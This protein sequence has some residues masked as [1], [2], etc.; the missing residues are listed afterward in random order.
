M[1]RQWII[2][3]SLPQLH[4]NW[5]Q[6]LPGSNLCMFS[7]GLSCPGFARLSYKENQG[8]KVLA[9]RWYYVHMY[10]DIGM[11][12]TIVMLNISVLSMILELK[13]SANFYVCGC[14]FHQGQLGVFIYCLWITFTALICM[15]SN[16]LW[17]S[18]IQTA[19]LWMCSF[20][21][22]LVYSLLL[23]PPLVFTVLKL[24]LFTLV[25]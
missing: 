13:M 20:V 1:D 12:Y 23:V 8:T 15:N 2:Q 21:F 5:V 10:T 17:L 25:T 9:S 14:T 11:S 16:S 3:T 24:P 18:Q 19:L 22:R 7:K 4:W 6:N